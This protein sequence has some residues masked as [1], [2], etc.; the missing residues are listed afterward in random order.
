MLSHQSSIR[1]DGKIKDHCPT[2]SVI[3]VSDKDEKEE[4]SEAELGYLIFIIFKYAVLII[5]QN[6]FQRIGSH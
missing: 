1:T 3:E 6:N 5:R 4:T 2:L